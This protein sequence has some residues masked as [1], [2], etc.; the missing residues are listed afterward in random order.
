MGL[1]FPSQ[2]MCIFVLN[3]PRERPSFSSSA[4]LFFHQLRVGGRGS[5]FHQRNEPPS[6]AFLPRQLSLA[7]L[8]RFASKFRLFASDKTLWPHF[9]TFHNVLVYPAMVRLFS[10]SKECHS[11]LCGG[12]YLAFLLVAFLAV[13][14]VLTSPTVRCLSLVYSSSLLCDGQSPASGDRSRKC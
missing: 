9:A 13:V 11:R 14:T 2:R 1:P 8:L 5:L 10:V 7:A 3:P 12:H 6:R 4:P